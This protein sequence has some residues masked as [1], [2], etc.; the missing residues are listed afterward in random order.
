M[1]HPVE[2][3]SFSSP[4]LTGL[5]LLELG[6]WLALYAAALYNVDPADR[7]PLQILFGGT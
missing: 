5:H 2:S 4:I 6:E 7:V 3:P 1:L